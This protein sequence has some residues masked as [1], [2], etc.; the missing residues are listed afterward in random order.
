MAPYDSRK[1]DANLTILRNFQL[2]NLRARKEDKRISEMLDQNPASL[3]GEATQLAPTSSTSTQT[4]PEPDTH[5]DIKYVLETQTLTLNIPF[6]THTSAFYV[7]EGF[8]TWRSTLLST[9]KQ[10]NPS[11]TSSIQLN[12][13]IYVKFPHYRSHTVSVQRAQ[14][15]ILKS[16]RRILNTFDI[17]KIGKCDVVMKLPEIHWTQVQALATFWDLKAKRWRVFL[18]E[19]EKKA[20]AVRSGDEWEK[21]L[22][23]E[24]RQLSE[25]LEL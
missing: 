15:E 24:H 17:E 5:P 21:R 3:S 11:R 12:V 6:D 4:E 1:A 16:T 22:R 10:H 19:G 20:I 18:K 9:L 13:I 2:H 14:R 23:D 25:R 8:A 7:S